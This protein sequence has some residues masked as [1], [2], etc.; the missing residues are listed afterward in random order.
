MLGMAGGFMFTGII[1]Q[2]GRVICV[3]NSRL[4]VEAPLSKLTIGESIAVNGVCLTLTQTHNENNCLSFDLSPETQKITAL[5]NLA[6]GTKVNLEQAMSATGRFGGHY[7]SGHVDAVSYVQSIKKIDNFVELCIGD[8]N[9][10]HQAYLLPKGSIAIDGISLTINS[11]HEN[12]I[13]LMLVPHTLAN[14]TLSDLQ[15]GQCVNIEFDYFARIIAHQL[16]L[17]GY[18][19][20]EVVL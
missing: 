2:C 8:F 13:Q 10:L 18:L 16:K 5:H 17:S 12:Q 7:V 20:N 19:K 6:K 4:I 14:T 15:V 3:E 1:E 9:L 11:L